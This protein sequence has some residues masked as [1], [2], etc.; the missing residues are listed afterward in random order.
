MPS[1]LSIVRNVFT[2]PEERTTAVGIWSGMGAAGFALGP[3]V[4][5]LL[6]DHFWWG[7]VFLINV[8]VMA[9]VLVAGARW[10]C[11]SRAT[12]APDGSTCRACCCRS[13]G[14]VAV[15]YAIKEAAHTGLEHADVPAAGVVGVALLVAFG[16]RQTRVPEPLIDVR[17]F[18]RRGVLRVDRHEPAGD[19]RDVGDDR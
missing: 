16:W 11:P 1:T 12:R 2:E 9:L 5:G 19:V 10:C 3:V 13:A 8:P 7:S 6:L 14:V 4:G 15:V 17:L 18:R